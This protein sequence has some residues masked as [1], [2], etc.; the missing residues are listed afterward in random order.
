MTVK[1]IAFEVDDTLWCNRLD[2]KY[3][4]KGRHA[5]S[6]IEDNLERVDDRLIRD[7][8]NHQNWIK[9]FKD[10]PNIVHDAVK[11]G[12]KLA[13]V[14][15]NPNRKL[16]DKAL[17]YYVAK[18]PHSITKGI[19]FMVNYDEVGKGDGKVEPF[20]RIKGWSGAQYDEMVY[21][22]SDYSSKKVYD[23]LGIK[24]V[25]VTKGL[26]WDTYHRAVEGGQQSDPHDTPYYGQPALGRHL[27]SGKFA[28]VYDC[29]DDERAVIKVLQNWT[30]E[31]RHR[32]LGIYSIIKHGKPFNPG[33]NAEDQYL[34]MVGLELRNL[35]KLRQLKAPKPEDFTGWFSMSKAEGVP[36]WKTPLY[37]KHPFS[38]P[39]QE[40]VR[41]GLHLAID[42][43]EATVKKDGVEHR[44]AHLANVYFTMHGDQPKKAHLLDWGIA[45]LMSWD[46]HRYVRGDDFLV[47]SDSEPGRKYTPEE[48]V[49]LS[50]P[51]MRNSGLL[52]LTLLREQ[53]KYWVKWMVKTEYEANMSRHNI[54]VEDGQK[55]LMDIDWWYHRP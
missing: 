6:P 11:K 1:V 26:D 42:E 16:V 46:G 47:W 24:F 13:I 39:F 35:D 22:D 50:F 53:R 14:S 31:R 54:T 19:I 45:V 28:T 3:W 48:F 41:A 8:S 20:K 18:D 7:K 23:Q 10:V 55:F 36:L 44:D 9:I 51:P 32:F 5:L 4:G 33:R 17:F 15:A 34:L 40:L 2:E 38:V 21:F 25:H 30:K 29:T 49:S 27:G 37:K 43:I 52:P 12:I